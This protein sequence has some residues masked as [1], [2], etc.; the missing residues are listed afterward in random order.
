MLV[1]KMQKLGLVSYSMT[2]LCH[3]EMMQF[4]L[5]ISFQMG[6]G[7][8]PTSPE[9]PDVY[10]S[11]SP[12]K[13]RKKGSVKALQ[14]RQGWT[15]ILVP[16]ESLNSSPLKILPLKIYDPTMGRIVLRPSFSGVIAVQLRGCKGLNYPECLSWTFWTLA[17][18]DEINLPPDGITSSMLKLVWKPPERSVGFHRFPVTILRARKFTKIGTLFDTV[19]HCFCLGCPRKFIFC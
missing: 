2:L 9:I 8:P 12:P 14:R 7:K 18:L 13:S 1:L 5:H 11:T 19:C 3:V 17:E 4:H 16:S 10:I 15:P 6:V